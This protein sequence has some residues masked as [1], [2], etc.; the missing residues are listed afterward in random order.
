M[1]YYVFP[2]QV[3]AL[4]TVA[5]DGATHLGYIILALRGKQVAVIYPERNRSA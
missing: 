5:D 1:A 3:L 2:N 4:N